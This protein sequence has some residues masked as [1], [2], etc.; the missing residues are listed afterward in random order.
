MTKHSAP[1]GT[2]AKLQRFNE[3]VGP[4][5]LFGTGEAVAKTLRI[6]A[7]GAANQG[8]HISEVL[9]VLEAGIILALEDSFQ[10]AEEDTE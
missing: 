7:G 6:L 9:D 1:F 3:A 4:N 2:A 5:K 10:A 8:Y